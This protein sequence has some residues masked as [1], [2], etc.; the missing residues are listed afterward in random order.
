MIDFYESDSTSL[1]YLKNFSFTSNFKRPRLF[2]NNN[3]AI[4]KLF[5]N[6]VGFGTLTQEIAKPHLEGGELVTLNGGAVME[7]P[8][9]LAWYPRPQMPTSFKDI[10]AA[11]KE[12]SIFFSRGDRGHL[13]PQ[14]F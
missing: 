9:A 13:G 2:V 7:D 12:V 4:L 3:E 11:V 5:C 10:I 1:N 8:L 6:G 14:T